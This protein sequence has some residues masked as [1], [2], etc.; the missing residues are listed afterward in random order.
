MIRSEHAKDDFTVLAG[1][2]KE[3]K[4]TIADVATVVLT[5]G[6]LLL[7]VRSNQIAQMKAGGIELQKPRVPKPDEKKSETTEE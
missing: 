6:K 1:K 4:V 3:G 2:V 5:I 7:S